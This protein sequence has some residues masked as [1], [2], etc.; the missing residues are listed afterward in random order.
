MKRFFEIWI[1]ILPIWTVIWNP[2]VNYSTICYKFANSRTMQRVTD[3]QMV[4]STR[5]FKLIFN[6]LHC[7]WLLVDNFAT[8]TSQNINTVLVSN[9][10]FLSEKNNLTQNNLTLYNNI[11][12]SGSKGCRFKKS[13]HFCDP[14]IVHV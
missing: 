11:M 13:L 5:K 8:H 4:S 3:W 1:R 12:P 6:I 10:H 9:M 2:D 7:V 14:R